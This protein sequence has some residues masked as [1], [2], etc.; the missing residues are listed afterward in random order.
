MNFNNIRKILILRGE[1]AL[2]DAV[3]SSFIFREIKKQYP[4]IKIGT[5]AFGACAE[6]YSRNK[7]I[8]ELYRLPIRNKIRSYQHWPELMWEDFKLRLKKFDIR[9]NNGNFG[10]FTKHRVIHEKLVF[11]NIGLKKFKYWLWYLFYRWS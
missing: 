9:H 5:V 2:S 4:N 6:Y 8:D 11:E 10:D 1:G 3:I 7:Y